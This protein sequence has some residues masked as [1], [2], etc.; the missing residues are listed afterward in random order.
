MST[1]KPEFRPVE[2]AAKRPLWPFAAMGAAI[3]ILLLVIARMQAAGAPK[4]VT[5]ANLATPPAVKA[6]A[7]AMAPTLDAAK[8]AVAQA[9]KAVEPAIAP[10]VKGPNVIGG[11]KAAREARLVPQSELERERARTRGAQKL[12]SDYKKQLSS[13]EKQL[14]VARNEAA[15]ARNALYAA[16]NPARPPPSD[17]EMILRTLAPVLSTANEG[18]Q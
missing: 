7:D 11:D 12:A 17:Q 1:D 4:Q 14:S 10:L 13:L 18:Q 15:Q 3:V 6:V 9:A 16:Q 5:T 2:I 8:G